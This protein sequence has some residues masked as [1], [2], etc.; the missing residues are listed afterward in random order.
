MTSKKEEHTVKIIQEFLKE[1]EVDG[2][3]ISIIDGKRKK[4]LMK[5]MYQLAE[6]LRDP[7]YEVDAQKI[8]KVDAIL[9]IGLRDGG[10]VAGMNC[11]ACGFPSCEDMLNNR[12][13]GLLFPGPTCIVKALRLGMTVGFFVKMH[14]TSYKDS[15]TMLRIGV[16]AKRLGFLKSDLVMGLLLA[17]SEHY[18]FDVP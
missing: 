7:L 1:L 18:R 5:Y 3:E 17:P 14:L 16:A 9:L 8:E 6:E 11:G 4:E 2:I 15:M 13:A 10:E 12:R